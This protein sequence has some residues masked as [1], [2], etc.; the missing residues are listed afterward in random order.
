MTRKSSC[1]SVRLNNERLDGGLCPCG[2]LFRLGVDRP[3]RQRVGDANRVGSTR[4]LSHATRSSL[5]TLRFAIIR[6]FIFIITVDG[7]S[8]LGDAGAVIV[9]GYSLE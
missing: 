4:E 7:G 9:G 6:L 8:D 2:S 3:S 1:E 5:Q